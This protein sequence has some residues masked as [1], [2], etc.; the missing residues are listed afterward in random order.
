[1]AFLEKTR[2][3]SKRTQRTFPAFL[4]KIRQ[5]PCVLCGAQAEAAHVRMSSAAHG[6]PFGKDDR[7]CV[8]LCPQHHRLGPECQHGAREETWWAGHGV[9]VL[10]VCVALWAAR[11]DLEKMQ[12]I[13]GCA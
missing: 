7:W 5:C 8:P 9:D 10:R 12:E 1:M 2:S 13:A 11:D 6:K 4:A 3:R